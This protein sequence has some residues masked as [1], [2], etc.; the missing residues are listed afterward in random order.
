MR[1]IRQ[2]VNPLS[3][4]YL[5]PHAQ[6]VVRP[7]HLDPGCAVE[8]EL[9]CADA[10]FSFALAEA[11]PER[12]VVG[13][14]IREP[15]IARNR[16]RA[17]EAGL[18]NLIFGYVNLN[19]DMDRVCA[20][21]SVDRFHLLFPDPW[22]KERHHK[23]RVIEPALVETLAAQL[24]P[25][26]ELH[27]ASDVFEIALEIMAT[28]EDPGLARLGLRNLAEPWGFW[29]G[30]PFEVASRREQITLRRGQRVWRMRYVLEDRARE[31]A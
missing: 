6:P 28:I 8:V 18:S 24:R 5:V 30:N 10:E 25:G 2:H 11:H 26:G 3:A 7:A 13:L 27:V 17:A 4:R 21:A 22:F 16:R 12:M 20:P 1:K 31:P 15:C 23:R 9:G 14:E 19:V 29:R